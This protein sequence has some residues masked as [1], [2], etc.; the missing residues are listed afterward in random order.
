MFNDVVWD[1]K[2]N[3]EQCV[4]NSRAVLR[5]MLANSLAVIGVSWGL[6]QKKNGAE[7]FLTNQMDHGIQWQKK[8]WRNSLDPVIRY[9]VPPV[10]L[11]EENYEAKEGERSQYTS[12]VAMKPSSCFSAKW[13]LR[14]SW[15]STQHWQIHDPKYPSVSGL[16]GNLQHQSIWK[17]WKSLPSSVREKIPPMN[18]SWK[19]AARIR[20]KNRAVVGRPEVIQTM[21]WCGF[22][23][24]W[25]RT[26]L[27]C[28]WNRR[29]T[30]D[31]TLMPRVH[32]ASQWRADSTERMDSK[33]GPVLNTEVCC[34]DEKFCIEV[35][36]PSLFQDNTVSWVRIVNGVDRYVTEST[37]TA[38]EENTASEKPI[39]RARPRQKLS[40][41]LTWI[42]TPALERIC[43]D[44]ETQR[45]N[46]QKCFE[47]WKAITRLLR[48]DHSVPR[49]ND[50]AI[51]YNAIIEECRRKKFDDASQWF[52]YQ[53]WQREEEWRK[54]SNFVWIQSLPI[55]S[56]TF[57]QF[58]DIQ[59]KVLL[60][61]HCTTVFW[62]RKVFPRRER[63]R[64]EFSFQKWINSRRNEPQKRKTNSLLHNSEPDGGRRLCA[65]RGKNGEMILLQTGRAKLNG[66]R[67][68]I[69]SR[70]WI[71][72]MVCRRS[73]SGKH[74]QDSRRWA[75]SKRFKIWWLIACEP[76]QFKGRIIFMSMCNNIVWRERGNT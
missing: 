65:L 60:I 14:I 24:C 7:P 16:R 25:T 30:T 73:S 67:R 9:F 51:H 8:W 11:R 10:P 42:S 47:V 37:P 5:N 69:T 26:K 44:T 35:Q 74:S 13:F 17:R 40:V 32:A 57:E 54:D 49:R 68:T 48:H 50:G 2:G 27:Q 53:N 75:S 1:A 36:V 22:E 6:D 20:A 55:N 64:I 45:S 46:D 38:A 15:V 70:N 23:A 3:K 28:S 18:S 71:A 63:E 66:I 59:K 43:I 52:G 41:T 39:A 72:S 34:R 29:K 4:H 21:L 19:P 56:C 76:E 62:F 31:A 58:K 61:L 33:L 12:L